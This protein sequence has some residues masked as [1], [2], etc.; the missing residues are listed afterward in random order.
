MK[1]IFIGSPASASA[2]PQFSE[3]SQAEGGPRRVGLCLTAGMRIALLVGIGLTGLLFAV[4]LI[5][6]LG[7]EVMNV[8]PVG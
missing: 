5:D 2:R 1:V 3:D 8:F 4:K 6:H 7:D